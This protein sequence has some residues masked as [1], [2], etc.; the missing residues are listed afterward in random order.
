MAFCFLES[1]LKHFGNAEITNFDDSSSSHEDVLSLQISMNN[2]AVVYVLHSET[3][4]CK[5]IENLAFRKWFPILSFD[6]QM[7]IATWKV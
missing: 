6:F 1:L 5:P 3:D 4:L 7:E 2:F